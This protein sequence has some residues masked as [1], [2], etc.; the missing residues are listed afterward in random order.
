MRKQVS[1]ATLDGF[2]AIHMYNEIKQNMLKFGRHRVM[3]DARNM[4]T[5]IRNARGLQPVENLYRQGNKEDG[6]AIIYVVWRERYKFGWGW[7]F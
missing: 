1:P 5:N 2:N 3:T 7:V 4:M 6:Q